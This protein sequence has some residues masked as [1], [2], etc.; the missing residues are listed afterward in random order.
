MQIQHEEAL[1]LPGSGGGTGYFYWDQCIVL[2]V[3]PRYDGLFLK[4]VQLFT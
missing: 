4:I 2:P 3:K 1:N